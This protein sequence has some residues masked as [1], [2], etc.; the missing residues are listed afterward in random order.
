[1]SDELST[2]G[3]DPAW[4]AANTTVDGRSPIGATFDGFIGTG[5]MSRNAR[6]NLDWG[7]DVGPASVVVKLPSSEANTRAIS[8]EHRV[9]ANECDFYSTLAAL[10]EVSAPEVLAVH[11]DEAEQDFAI[12]MEDLVGY[13]QGDQ[14]T[15]ATDAQLELAIDQAVALQAPV[16]GQID[17]EPFRPFREA[18]ETRTETM[19]MFISGF[20]PVVFERLGAGLDPEVSALLKRFEQLVGDWIGLRSEPTSLVHGDFRPDNFM[21]AEGDASPPMYVVDWQTLGVGSGVTDIAYLL[22]AAVTPERRREIEHGMLDRYVGALA[23]RGVDYPMTECLA[24]YALGSLHG[25]VI[26]TSATVMADHTERGDAL[27]TL[28]LNRHGRHALDLGIL[29]RVEGQR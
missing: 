25:V 26:A 19:S 21:F 18:V 7:D 29:D 6:F 28:M 16:W 2:V 27:F 5:Q 3:L 15:D 14:F 8:F 24:D 13:R 23:E 22:G 12:V 17:G 1:M 4:V 9:Y 20:L 11:F 10:V